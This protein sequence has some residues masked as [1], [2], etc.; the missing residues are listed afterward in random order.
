MTNSAYFSDTGGL[1]DLVLIEMFRSGNELA[2]TALT[3]RYAALIRSITSKYNISGLESEDL[4]QEGLLGLLSAANTYRHD[5]GAS[6]KTYAGLCINRNIISLLRCCG[7]SKGKPLNDYISLYDDGVEQSMLDNQ[8]NPENL[9]ISKEEQ[10]ELQ[11]LNERMCEH[12][13]KTEVR[14]LDLYL[15]GKSYRQIADSLSVTEKSVD[16]ALQRVRRKLK[17]H[18]SGICSETE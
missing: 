13:S 12:L 7:S 18:I 16:N 14:V 11:D 8:E 2:F 1:S 3:E 15:A 9:V 4:T 17:I 6:F 10:R 5:G